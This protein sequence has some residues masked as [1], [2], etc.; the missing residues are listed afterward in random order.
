MTEGSQIGILYFFCD[1]ERMFSGSVLLRF[2]FFDNEQKN[3]IWVLYY[4]FV[5]CIIS[6]SIV[7]TV[8]NFLE[9]TK[10][11]GVYIGKR[12]IN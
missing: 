2:N 4:F 5:Y 1:T 9:G 12:I 3:I 7:P 11:G 8:T 10:N 6:L